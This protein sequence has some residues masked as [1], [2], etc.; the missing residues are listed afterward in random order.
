MAGW[1][2]GQPTSPGA[3]PGQGGLR[4]PRGG[5]GGGEKQRG[6]QEDVTAAL[7]QC[8]ASSSEGCGLGNPRVTGR[9]AFSPNKLGFGGVD[10]QKG[11]YGVTSEGKLT[12][13]PSLGSLWWADTAQASSGCQ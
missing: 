2:G 12:T 10:E 6:L 5:G 13:Q 4:P 3:R 1:Q 7:T 11:F 9:V 8:V